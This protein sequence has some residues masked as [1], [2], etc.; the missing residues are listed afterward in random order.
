MKTLIAFL[1]CLYAFSTVRAQDQVFC[2][3]SVADFSPAIGAAASTSATI[4]RVIIRVQSGIYDFSGS[5]VLSGTVLPVIVRKDLILVGGY[6]AGCTLRTPNANLTVFRNTN[7]QGG[8]RFLNLQDLLIQGIFFDD[9]RGNLSSDAGTSGADDLQRIEFSN[10][11]V[12]LGSGNFTL[13][14]E[15][16][17]GTSLLILKN[18]VIAGRTDAQCVLLLAGDIEANTDVRLIFSNNTVALNNSGNSSGTVCLSEIEQP[19]FYNN[20]LLGNVGGADL[21]ALNDVGA[22]QFINNQ[23]GALVGITSSASSGGNSPTSPQYLNA[24][25]GDFR[26]TPTSVGINS[27]TATVPTGTGTVDLNGEVR[28]VG[29]AVDRG[30]HESAVTGTTDIIVSNTNDSGSGSLRTAMVQANSTPGFNRI[31]FNIAGSACPKVIN[32]ASALPD[33]SESLTIDGS[34]QPGYV[35]NT[36]D[37][38][39]NGTR[40]VVLR[41]SAGT[42]SF[43]LEVPSSAASD[44]QLTLDAVAFGGFGYAVNLA[45]GRGHVITGSQFGGNVGSTVLPNNDGGIWVAGASNVRIGGAE[46]EALNSFAGAIGSGL[47]PSAGILISSGANETEIIRNF[48]GFG[49][50]GTLEGANSYGIVQNGDGATIINNVIGNNL[51]GIWLTSTAENNAVSN[52]RIGEPAFCFLPPC[53]FAGNAVGVRI[54]GSNNALVSNLTA[55]NSG[56]GVRVEGDSNSI[57]AHLSFNNGEDNLSVPPIDIASPGFTLNDN[58]GATPAPAG[59]RGQNYP[60]LF[61]PNFRL[62]GNLATVPGR[63]DSRNGRYRISV[64][65]GN[66]VLAGLRCEANVA[67]WSGE[68]DI[69]NAP[70]GENGS[71]SFN[72]S[73]LKHLAYGKQLSA[74]ATR[75]ELIAPSSDFTDTSE[76]G[77]C[78]EAPWVVDGFE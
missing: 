49:A 44:T 23:L 64:Y 34:T 50:N 71:A 26:L 29:I 28:T 55:Q 36:N 12:F 45:G 46:F 31:V 15:S 33:I 18:N 66:R 42:L 9:F 48:I 24:L 32:L 30:A 62:S 22:A 39:Y 43:G 52:N 77:T 56:P 53:T 75:V 35:P 67:L 38:S 6:N 14:A 78:V 13:R 1:L 25:A 20:L 60:F 3:A 63:L 40:C 21:R 59:N 70:P 69:T 54:G 2:V 8:M 16:G 41:P 17:A 74:T 57:L 4:D 10:N 73:V 61:S 58:D 5:T 7:A 76:Y 37:I 68:I 27:G 11:K 72:A 47:I 65:G 19:S 51:I